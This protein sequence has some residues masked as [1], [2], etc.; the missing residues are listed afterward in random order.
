MPGS[1]LTA[2]AAAKPTPNLPTAISCAPGPRLAEARSVDNA[3]TSAASSGAPTFAAT[4]V[5]APK[6]GRGVREVEDGDLV[7]LR[8]HVQPARGARRADVL[9]EGVEVAD[10]RRVQDGRS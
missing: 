1:S 3:A 7:P 5:P 4:S 2:T 10:R 6:H 9:L 8:G